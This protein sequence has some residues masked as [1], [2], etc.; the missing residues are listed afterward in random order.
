MVNLNSGIYFILYT[1]LSNKSRVNNLK[2]MCIDVAVNKY[3]KHPEKATS[4]KNKWKPGVFQYFLL[5]IN[6]HNNLFDFYI[7][8]TVVR[9]VGPKYWRSYVFVLVLNVMHDLQQI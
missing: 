7:L 6:F 1:N 3:G 4:F 2:T 9:L 5:H 8:E